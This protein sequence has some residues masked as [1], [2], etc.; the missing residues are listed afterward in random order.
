[1]GHLESA[2]GVAGLIKAVLAVEKGTI[3]PNI[4][5][6]TPN[7]DIPFDDWRITVPTSSTPWPA[8]TIRRVSINSFGAG[9]TNAHAVI[10]GAEDYLSRR[11]KYLLNGTSKLTEGLL[12]RKRVFVLRADDQEGIARQKQALLSHLRGRKEEVQEHAEDQYLLKLAYTLLNRRSQLPWVSHATGSSFD[13][14]IQSLEDPAFLTARST[15]TS[16]PFFVFAGQGAQWARMGVELLHYPVFGESVR[17]ADHY[18]VETLGCSW[19]VVE[20]LEKDAADSIINQAAYSQSLSTIL[21][22]A[23]VQLL[24]SWNV[25]PTAVVGHSSG[26]IAAAYCTGAITREQAWKI[27][28]CKGQT[29]PFLHKL[30]PKAEGAMLAAGTSEE[31][32]LEFISKVKSGKAVVACINSAASITFSGD[33]SA[34][35]EIQLM[36]KEEKIFERRLRVDHA[37]HSHHMDVISDIFRDRIQNIHP[38]PTSGSIKMFSSVSGKAIETEQLVPDYWIRNMV[39]PVRFS[40]ACQEMMQS[41]ANKSSPPVFLEVGPHST[42]QGPVKQILKQ[43]EINDTTYLSALTR[44]KDSI[45]TALGCAAQLVTAGIPV[46]LTCVNRD[47]SPALVKLRRPLTDLPSYAWN[48]TRSFWKESR[49]SKEYR[50]RKHAKMDLLPP[51]IPSLGPNCHIWRG[52]LRQSEEPW[53]SDHQIQGS[54]IYPAAGFISMAVEAARQISESGRD[55]KIYRLR[56]FEISHAAVIPDQ[57]DLEAILQLRPQG[58]T[59]STTSCWW[60]FT[61]S[62]CV[63]GETLRQNCKG[64]LQ[65]EYQAPP[66]SPMA[67]ESLRHAELLKTKASG[68]R[69]NCTKNQEVS[70]FYSRL[71]GLGLQYGPTFR[72]VTKIQSGQNIST[73]TVTIPDTGSSFVP[74]NGQRSHIVHPSTLDAILHSILAGTASDSN[75]STSG[76]VPT[77]IEEITIDSSIPYSAQEQLQVFSEARQY[78]FRGMRSDAH[79]FDSDLATPYLSLNGVFWA[80]IDSTVAGIEADVTKK[81]CFKTEWQPS[82]AH[83]KEE[84]LQRWLQTMAVY[85]KLPKV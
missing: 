17:S 28:Y 64:L 65:L 38:K 3:P 78:G 34:I 19:S 12:K 40:Q 61:I 39:S 35:D 59:T 69:D 23:L 49:L 26:E 44:G 84:D 72:G 37:Y 58:E 71:D 55:V 10:E 79:T 25:V 30:G 70:K 20:E 5:F 11:T 82:L 57:E 47:D 31:K 77:K 80:S 56:D 63:D 8:G 42:L 1:M 36:L 2:A 7:P 9:G 22:V 18:L 81:I 76:M 6:N 13:E 46:D 32:G 52:F 41:A 51:A 66:E 21:Q 75:L 29:L 33:E 74:P 27:S 60:D 43:L 4:Y 16:K 45:D 67:K 73:C 85:E 53:I 54:V 62:T 14:L 24:E 83:S 50:M 15:Q 48:H 68:I